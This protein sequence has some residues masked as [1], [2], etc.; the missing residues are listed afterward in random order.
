MKRAGATEKGPS[1]K[2]KYE[3]KFKKDWEGEFPGIV[4]CK[5]THKALCTFC[6]IEISISSG[7]KGD[8]AKHWKGAPHQKVVQDAKKSG[9][10]ARITDLRQGAKPISHA[11][12]VGIHRS[13]L[14]FIS[15]GLQDQPTTAG[16]PCLF[17]GRARIYDGVATVA[18]L[19]QNGLA[20][21]SFK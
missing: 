13:H 15:L 7:G 10:Q 16:P 4:A 17:W 18:N 21:H 1:N 14:N 6:N 8:I 19:G 11:D 2:K 3:S 12:K 5:D 20:T 9:K